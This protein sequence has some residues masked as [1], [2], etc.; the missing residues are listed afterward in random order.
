MHSRWEAANIYY[1]SRTE[2]HAPKGRHLAPNSLLPSP[3]HVLPCR[4]RAPAPFVALSVPAHAWPCG[5]PRWGSTKL[6]HS[7]ARA[8]SGFSSLS[9]PSA[10]RG[11]LQLPRPPP[12]GCHRLRHPRLCLR[13]KWVHSHPSTLSSWFLPTLR[14]S[15]L[16]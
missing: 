12:C 16:S 15:S 6:S 11:S 1:S 13:G 3:S 10:V 2:L 5:T 7:R 8:L 14:V 4:S 9:L